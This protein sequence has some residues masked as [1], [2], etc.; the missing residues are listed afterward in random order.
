MNNIEITKDNDKI[1]EK[2]RSI[3]LLKEH[4]NNSSKSGE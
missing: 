4:S 2:S 1:I 3:K